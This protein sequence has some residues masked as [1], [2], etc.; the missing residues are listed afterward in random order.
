MSKKGD[1]Y[2]YRK[3]E[4]E[5]E[6]EEGETVEEEN[7]EEGEE[8]QRQWKSSFYRKKEK[9]AQEPIKSEKLDEI[10]EIVLTQE[11]KQAFKQVLENLV[12]SGKNEEQPLYKPSEETY[13]V[14]QSVP[15]PIIEQEIEM[16]PEP[17]EEEKVEQKKGWESSIHREE[18]FQEVKETPIQETAERKIVKKYPV[19]PTV[20]TNMVASSLLPKEKEQ[21]RVGQTSTTRELSEFHKGKG[22]F[23]VRLHRVISWWL[24]VITI[25][26]ITLGY[27]ITESWA[28]NL[29]LVTRFH[30]IFEWSFMGLL[31]YHLIYTLIFVRLNTLKLVKNFKKHWV[32]IIQKSTKWLILLFA[33]LIILAGFNRYEWAVIFFESWLPFRWHRFFD[34]FLVVSIIL[35][36]MAGSKI[37]FNRH[38]IRNWWINIPI[39]LIGITLIA[40]AI[41]LEIARLV[42]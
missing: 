32:R 36:T 6:E 27:T 40:G 33:T 34:S 8:E 26:T 22:S 41:Y 19:V 20:K 21:N 4:E 7:H 12:E 14:Q 28:T 9:V 1:S 38:K 42:I 10:P 3:E 17:D 11:D 23:R 37:F 5:E 16:V 18:S 29:T 25:I 15:E 39:I 13:P 2:F 30:M 35:H 24:V 31:A